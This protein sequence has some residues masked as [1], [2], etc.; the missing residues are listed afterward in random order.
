MSS[1]GRPGSTPS[2]MSST[3]ASLSPAHSIPSSLTEPQQQTHT[4]RPNGNGIASGT[5][6][7]LT[8]SAVLTSNNISTNHN[9]GSNHVDNNIKSVPANQQSTQS[10]TG[11]NSSSSSSGGGTRQSSSPSVNAVPTLGSDQSPPWALQT[12]GPTPPEAASASSLGGRRGRV[13]Q[14]QGQSSVTVLPSEHPSPPD[15]P[16]EFK[17]VIKDGVVSNTQNHTDTF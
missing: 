12:R 5:N 17:D 9:V 13:A 11:N 1:I 15:S 4:A 7:T 8:S 16:H 2:P 14:C 10:L 6:A 3:E